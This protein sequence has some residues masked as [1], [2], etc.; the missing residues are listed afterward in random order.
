MMISTK[1]Y[2][3]QYNDSM[4]YKFKYDWMGNVEKKSVT[5]KINAL[6]VIK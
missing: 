6:Y 3:K 5:K 1:D 2:T 4:N